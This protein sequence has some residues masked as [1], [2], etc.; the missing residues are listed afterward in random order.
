M[1][2]IHDDCVESKYFNALKTKVFNFRFMPW[3]FNQ[4]T[5]YTEK[6][7][8]TFDNSFNHIAVRNYKDVS[9]MAPY[10]R[11]CIAQAFFKLGEPAPEIIRVRF[12]LILN[13][14]H[15]KIHGPHIDSHKPHQTGLLYLNDS[16]GDTYFYDNYYDPSLDEGLSQFDYYK[17][18]VK[19]NLKEDQSV[20]PKANRLALFDGYQYHASSSPVN[21]QFRIVMNFNYTYDKSP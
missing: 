5:A 18:F 3:F 21:T 14:P 13:A 6:S 9:M 17:K 12:G 1:I 7:T 2:Q 10:A 11:M 8:D 16:D 4:F 20:T 19:D 15:N